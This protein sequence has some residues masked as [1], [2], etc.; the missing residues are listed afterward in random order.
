MNARPNI[1]YIHSHDTGRTI[2]PYG[3]AVP[4]PNLQRLAEQGVLFRQ[5][6]SAAPTCSPSRAALLTGR[7]PHQVGMFGN[8]GRG[9]G[10][11]DYGQH[12]AH[13]LRRAGYTSALAGL[14]HIAR[15][16]AQIGYDR[17]LGPR[18]TAH[19][20]A[21]A[22]LENAPPQPF[23]L[24]VGFKE[25]HRPF[26]D[27]GELGSAI[28]C[29]PPARL[30]VTPE[31]VRDMAA[32]RQ[33]AADLDSKV[34]T[35]LGALEQ[36]GLAEDT[37]VVYTTDHGLAFPDMKSTL[38][39]DGIGVALIVRGPGGF[40][41]GRAIEALVSH[42]D[43]YPTLCELAGATHPP[44]SQGESLLPL[45]SGTVSSVR[46]CAFA[47]ITFHACYE[48]RRC[49]RTTR[50]KYIRRFETWPQAIVCNIDDSPSKDVWMRAGWNERPGAEAEQLYDLL[51]D[52]LEMVNLA[53]RPDH[54]EV[55]A[56]MRDR[57]ARWMEDTDDP[58]LHGPVRAP[59]GTRVNRPDCLSPHDEPEVIP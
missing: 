24:A 34:G 18:E 35:V 17:I 19:E 59:S 5:A 37:V 47:E 14:Q 26:P 12:I 58:L 6:F 40:R 55:L 9:F 4:T 43:L 44:G 22:F 32:Y 28:P 8:V 41:D 21:S 50:F 53:G 49:A 48:P 30:P 56:E 3:Y 2:Q 11:W 39:D 46:E 10:L 29:R 1:V 33:S 54:A 7:Y 15:D 23:F 20:T 27:P 31:T 36:S 25:T 57:L 52:P 13:T 51:F 42:L 38:R 45:V 16:S